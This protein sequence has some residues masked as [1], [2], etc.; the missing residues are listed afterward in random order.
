MRRV[1]LL[2]IRFYAVFYENKLDKNEAI[3]IIAIIIKNTGTSAAAAII[4]VVVVVVVLT[5]ECD[6]GCGSDCD[7]GCV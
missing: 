1:I 4:F 6:C 2:G 3:N 7:C 5:A